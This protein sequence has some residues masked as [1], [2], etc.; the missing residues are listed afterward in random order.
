MRL[1][2][3]GRLPL[4]T[5]QEL[6]GELESNKRRFIADSN[7][8]ELTRVAMAITHVEAYRQTAQK[9]TVYKRLSARHA[10]EV[11]SVRQELRAF[12]SE[13]KG[14]LSALSKQHAE[15]RDAVRDAH[16]AELRSLVVSWRSDERM[17]RYSRP[18]NGLIVR[19]RQLDLLMHGGEY[20]QAEL[21]AHEIESIESEEAAGRVAQIKADYREARRKMQIRRAD[22]EAA[23]DRDLDVERQLV[24]QRRAQERRVLTNVI[25]KLDVKREA[26]GE[27]EKAWQYTKVARLN[28]ISK[29]KQKTAPREPATPRAKV[30]ATGRFEPQARAIRLPPLD[31]DHI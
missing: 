23:L 24:R 18:P 13:T 21:V 30:R 27:P 14:I 19:R 31:F 26:F 1:E 17:R 2:P 29:N 12:D 8:H 10:E 20:G 7:L 16:A 9:T 22:E 25:H 4:S 3:L 5:Y 6:L 11:A 15:Q 28:E